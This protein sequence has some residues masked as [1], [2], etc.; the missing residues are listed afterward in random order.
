MSTSE[1]LAVIPARGGSKGLP[2]KNILDLGGIP[3]VAWSIRSALACPRVT[4]VIVSTEDKEIAAVAREYGAEVPF[5]RPKELAGDRSLPG[6]AVQH[7]LDR[8]RDDHGY[9][10]QAYCTLYPTHPFRPAALVGEAVRLA[11]EAYSPV[12]AARRIDTS[13]RPYLLP[14]NDG[15]RTLKLH[16]PAWRPYGL[17][18]A[19]TLI[20]PLLGMRLLPVDDPVTL[21]DIDAESD[22][23]LA[24]DAVREGLAIVPQGSP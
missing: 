20:R 18:E 8:L 11:L 21:L 15:W 17:V 2:R 4:R 16:A 1:V 14:Q 19:K 10:P 13:H 7:V 3:L 23:L 5:L 6:H 12:V 24:R 22:L 9:A